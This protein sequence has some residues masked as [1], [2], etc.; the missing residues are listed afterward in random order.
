MVDVDSQFEAVESPRTE[1]PLELC[2][3][4]RRRQAKG[5]AL[6]VCKW[7]IADLPDRHRRHLLPMRGECEL[8]WRIRCG[9][10]VNA[11]WNSSQS[12]FEDSKD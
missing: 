2:R 7:Q 1:K 12:R 10:S 8:A 11:L 4:E 6:Q 5:C 9:E 3:R